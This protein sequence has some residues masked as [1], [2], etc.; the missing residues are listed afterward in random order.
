MPVG[1]APDGTLASQRPGETS[2]SVSD[3]TS[4]PPASWMPRDMTEVAG[5]VPDC[6]RVLSAGDCPPPAT[7]DR[8][9]SG[10]YSVRMTF[11]LSLEPPRTEPAWSD[12]RAVGCDM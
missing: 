11:L 3:R 5:T 2:P 4:L 6:G 10:R 7:S 12:A 9:P 1:S 8:V